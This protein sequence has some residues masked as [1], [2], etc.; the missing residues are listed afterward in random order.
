MVLGST[1][2]QLPRPRIRPPA[3]ASSSIE[4]EPD[5][6]QL[7]LEL[8]LVGWREF[9]LHKVPVSNLQRD[10]GKQ[11]C[12]SMVMQSGGDTTSRGEAHLHGRGVDNGV[13]E[14]VILCHLF[15]SDNL[16]FTGVTLIVV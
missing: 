7:L 15:R 16:R 6:V 13:K 12:L 8:G 10:G 14:L 1:A 5:P 11:V 9:L 3:R 4:L 2:A